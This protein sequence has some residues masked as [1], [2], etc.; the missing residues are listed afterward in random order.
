MALNGAAS[1]V[2]ADDPVPLIRWLAR[3]PIAGHGGAD[4]ECKFGIVR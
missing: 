2:E 4:G 3:V 1:E